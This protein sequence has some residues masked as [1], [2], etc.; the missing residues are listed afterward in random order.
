MPIYEFSCSA[1]SHRFERLVRTG[2]VP[3]CPSCGSPRLER[4][5]SLFAV[6]SEGTRSAALA[7]GRRQA[8]KVAGE[9]AAAQREYEAKHDDHH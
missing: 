5:V 9:K 8:G 7:A 1:C 4:I 6:N 3:E 2:D